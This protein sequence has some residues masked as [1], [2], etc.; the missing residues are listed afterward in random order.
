MNNTK[1]LRRALLGGAALSAMATVANA[2]ELTALKAQ[3]EALQSRVSQLE[4]QPAPQVPPGTKLLTVRRGQGSYSNAAALPASD[5]LHDHQGYTIAITPT[6]DMPAPVSEVTVSGE[7]RARMIY[8]TYEIDGDDGA[9]IDLSADSVLDTSEYVGTESDTFD[10]TTRARLRVD[11]RTETA[12]GEVGGTIRLEGTRDVT[13]SVFDDDHEVVL[14]IG[15][16]YW[17]MTPSLQL[18]AG[19]W[20]SLAAIQAG[21]DWNGEPS[22]VGL[23]SGP[24]NHSVSQFRLTYSSGGFTAAVSLEDNDLNE[25]WENAPGDAEK[26]A[27]FPSIA[28][29]L[30]F[31]AGSFLVT[32]S[33]IYQPD[34]DESIDGTANFY[35]DTEDNWWVGAGAIIRLSDM[36][37]LEGAAGIGEG[38]TSALYFSAKTGQNDF[39]FW[40][41]SLMAVI[42]FAEAWRLELGAAYLEFEHEDDELVVTDNAVEEIWTVGASAFWD[43]VD[44]LTLGVGVG[45]SHAEAAEADAE[46][47]FITAGFGAWFRF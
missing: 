47:D 24:T 40:N 39:E 44:Q 23:R 45:F 5:R 22:L 2:D 10:I 34:D 30:A 4:S 17:Q 32:A 42:S 15:W 14:N 7:I 6:A 43:P 41:A 27:V 33:G 36:F 31:D 13:G 37:R 26:D 35:N 1:W 18:G 38:Y 46:A 16:G 25:F 8:D 28:A 19:Y 12:I 21:W 11:G 3:L 9:F 29:H 20:D